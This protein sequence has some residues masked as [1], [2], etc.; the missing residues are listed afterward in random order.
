MWPLYT[1]PHIYEPHNHLHAHP[2]HSRVN[3]LRYHHF[4]NG[5]IRV[6]FVGNTSTC[7]PTHHQ[8][9]G[10]VMTTCGCFPAIHNV[11]DRELK[12][13]L[14]QPFLA[15]GARDRRV[16]HCANVD[17][18]KNTENKNKHCAYMHL[19]TT[20]FFYLNAVRGR[21]RSEFGPARKK[22]RLHFFPAS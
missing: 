9:F 16:A 15:A 18:N 2:S 4:G 10:V 20:F 22:G 17:K 5:H 6:D 19:R 21:R 11:L 14:T 13:W 3:W 12:W 1:G 7:I 8:L